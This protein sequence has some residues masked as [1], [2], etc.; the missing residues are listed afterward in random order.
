LEEELA[1]LLGQAL[2]SRVRQGQW[3]EPLSGPPQDS[4]QVGI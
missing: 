1:C 3:R 4:Q 2:L